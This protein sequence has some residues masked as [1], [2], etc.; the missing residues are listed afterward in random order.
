MK[1]SPKAFECTKK[2][3]FEATLKFCITKKIFVDLVIMSLTFK[4]S[5]MQL[6]GFERNLEKL[7]F[8]EKKVKGLYPVVGLKI[9]RTGSL[10]YQTHQQQVPSF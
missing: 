1:A 3:L 9:L 4:K 8:Q 7:L 2:Q 6:I 10:L 5:L